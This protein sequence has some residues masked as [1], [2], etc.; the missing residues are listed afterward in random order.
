MLITYTK[1]DDYCHTS[2][3]PESKVPKKFIRLTQRSNDAPFVCV[4]LKCTNRERPKPV[5][6]PAMKLYH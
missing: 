2:V 5:L 4:L 3:A 1:M 6:I